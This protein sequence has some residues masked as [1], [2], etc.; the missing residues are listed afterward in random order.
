MLKYLFMLATLGMI[1]TSSMTSAVELRDPE[2][3]KFLGNLSS[4]QYD[5]DSVSNPYGQYGSKYSPDSVN[6]PYGEYGSKY[7]PKSV[8]NPY[9]VGSP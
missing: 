2:T 4:N 5:P 3:G 1:M 7:S 6:N 8:N 9:A